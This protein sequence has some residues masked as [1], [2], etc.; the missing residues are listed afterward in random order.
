MELPEGAQDMLAEALSGP[1]ETQAE[2][3]TRGYLTLW[4][5]PA[6]SARMQALARSALSNEAASE[7]TQALL[8]GAIAGP[9]V[10]PLLAGRRTGF[11][12]AMAQLLGVASTRYLTH[13]PQLVE[14]DFEN[15]VARTTPVVQ[16]HLNAADD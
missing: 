9:G 3:L 1:L 6:T 7:R 12:L 11:T 15:L 14:L 2:R 5:D 4:E 8:T 10:A 13:V 16:L